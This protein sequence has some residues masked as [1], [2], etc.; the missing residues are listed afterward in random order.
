[1]QALEL[2]LTA[3]A[4]AMDAFAVAIATGVALRC[5]TLRQTLRLAWH[6][7]LFQALMP[8]TGWLLGA[9]VRHWVEA[10]AHWVA[11]ALLAYIGAR[12]I[13]EALHDHEDGR[14][15]CDPTRGMT[16]I[17]LSVATSIDALAVGLSLSVLGIPV[18]WPALVIGAVALGFTALGMRLGRTMA[19]ARRVGRAAEVL[20]G[21]VLLGIGIKILADHGALPF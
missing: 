6:F 17:M 19:R 12:M 16:L 11:F 10:W 5:A 3:I 13:I 4:L 14:P 1:V 2:L 21:V 8:I 7:G 18:W 20:G 15:T 9:T